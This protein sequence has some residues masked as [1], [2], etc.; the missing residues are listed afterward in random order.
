M[1][2]RDQLLPA[3]ETLLKEVPEIFW[4]RDTAGGEETEEGPH[5]QQFGITM[6]LSFAPKGCQAMK[7][8]LSHFP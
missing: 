8:L 5:S 4:S 2:V 1:S 6:G 7:L 3:A